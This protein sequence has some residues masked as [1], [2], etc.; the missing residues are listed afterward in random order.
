MIIYTENFKKIYIFKKQ[1]VKYATN[2]VYKYYLNAI[3]QYKNLKL[4]EYLSNYIDY[5]LIKNEMNR[6]DFSEFSFINMKGLIIFRTRFIKDYIDNLFTIYINELIINSKHSEF[7]NQLNI[8]IKSNINK[9]YVL[10]MHFKENNSVL[11]ILSKKE[12]SVGANRKFLINESLKKEFL[13]DFI[14]KCKPGE[15]IIHKINFAK[16]RNLIKTI[17]RI[18]GK[19]FIVLK[20]Y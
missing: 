19:Q 13:L 12:G 9:N 6:V 4:F 20:E 16:N 7:I 15:I 1:I 11:L 2:E 3:S 10:N 18:Y 8:Y 17:Y 14:L 5:S